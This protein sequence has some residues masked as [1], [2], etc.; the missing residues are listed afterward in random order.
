MKT[1]YCTPNERDTLKTLGI[2]DEENFVDIDH[3]DDTFKR[4]KH[5]KKVVKFEDITH[6]IFNPKENSVIIFDRRMIER[7]FKYLFEY[8]GVSFVDKLFDLWKKRNVKVLF[9]FAFF[10]RFSVAVI[11]C[12]LPLQCGPFLSKGHI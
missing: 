3:F 2:Y 7:D 4:I 10:L 9:N 11:I 12:K 8:Y 6:P 1:I 5:R